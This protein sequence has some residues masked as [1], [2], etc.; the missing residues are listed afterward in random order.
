MSEI[1]VLQNDDGLWAVT[2]PNLVVTGL[3]R[4]AAVAFA[5]SYRRL[6]DGHTP[7]SP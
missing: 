2:A 1:S 3:T 7:P 4:E 6:H 5:E